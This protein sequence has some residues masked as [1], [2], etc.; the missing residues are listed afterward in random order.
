[1]SRLL[2]LKHFLFIGIGLWTIIGICVPWLFIHFN[3]ILY[4]STN[5]NNNHNFFSPSRQKIISSSSH[6]RIND[7][8]NNNNNE[9]K[10]VEIKRTTKT[11]LIDDDD[12]NNKKKEE[13]ST[14]ILYHFLVNSGC[15]P[16]QRWQVLTQIH[17]AISVKQGGKYTWLRRKE[18]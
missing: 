17:S 9:T 7:D 1:M 10:L 14:T 11:K 3:H 5:N 4:S 18:K 6:S 15:S 8:D 16:Y 13:P 12:Y 2:T